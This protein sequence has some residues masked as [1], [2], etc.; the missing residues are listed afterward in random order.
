MHLEIK[1][2]NKSKHIKTGEDYST[3]QEVAVFCPFSLHSFSS[4]TPDKLPQLIELLIVFN[5][6]YKSSSDERHI[7]KLAN[8][9]NIRNV[10]KFKLGGIDLAIE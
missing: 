10:Y 7:F 3:L 6:V 9:L 2:S 8:I 4:F 1:W 5:K